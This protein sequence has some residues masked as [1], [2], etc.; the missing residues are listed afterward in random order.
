VLCTCAILVS[1]WSVGYQVDSA[2]PGLLARVRCVC[3]QSRGSTMLPSILSR[4]C[5]GRLKQ[6]AAEKGSPPAAAAANRAETVGTVL[7]RRFKS[8][9]RK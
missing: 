6:E 1:V 5:H 7:G 3:S 9:F 4:P 8:L 2:A